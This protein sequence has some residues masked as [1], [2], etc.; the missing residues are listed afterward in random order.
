MGGKERVKS[1]AKYV[2]VA[3]L[4]LVFISAGSVAVAMYV[5]DDLL[6][7]GNA[8]IMVSKALSLQCA[9][10]SNATLCEDVLRQNPRIIGDAV[11]AMMAAPLPLGFL[12]A[13]VPIGE[14]QQLMSYA[15]LLSLLVVALSAG[16]LALLMRS[17]PRWLKS[18]GGGAF[19]IG[20]PMLALGLLAQQFLPAYLQLML[21]QQLAAQQVQGAQ[22]VM[23][24]VPGIMSVISP[25]IGLSIS[26][27]IV[28]SVTGAI[29]FI[30]GIALGRARKRKGEAV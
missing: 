19:L 27:G 5:F 18:I 10:T 4:S 11:D 6:S 12:N 30:G 7:R 8:E 3:L 1:F 20:A 28:L 9:A 25:K 26:L 29:I 17:L 14:L 23:A 16:G 13:Q 21:E 2:A 22:L 24:A 15:L